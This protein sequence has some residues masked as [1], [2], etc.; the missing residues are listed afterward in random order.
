MSGSGVSAG[1]PVMFG[2]LG[3][4]SGRVY[5]GQRTACVRLPDVAIFME[6]EQKVSRMRRITLISFVLA[7]SAALVGSMAL[8]ASADTSSTTATTVTVTG[9]GLAITAPA[10]ASL[11]GAAPGATATANL[12]G[13]RVADTRAG[14]VGWTASVLS[15][16]LTGTITGAAAIPATAAM[17]TPTGLATVTGIAVVTP[18]IQTNLST[19]KPVQTASA[20]VGNN[21]ATWSA[22]LSVAVPG[23]ALA[24]T[25]SGTLTH[26]VL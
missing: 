3:D 22:A 15:S 14:T 5:G 19:A 4:N 20:V 9:G 6:I 11:S 23:A 8:P 7:A 10:S 24:D 25:Y 26:S 18:T 13:V 1:S 16:D 21:S 12:T 2:L 17:Y